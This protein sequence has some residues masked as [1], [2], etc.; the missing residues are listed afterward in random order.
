MHTPK[1]K[2]FTLIELLVVIAIIAILAAILFP[3]FAQARSAAK[4]TQVISNA[5]QIG[6]ASIMYANDHDD[7]FSPIANFQ[8]GWNLWSFVT[9]VEPYIKNFG[10]FMDPLGPAN[11][12]DNPFI[13]NSQWAMAPR[14]A[15]VTACPADTDTTGCALGAVNPAGLALAGGTALGRDGIAG[16]NKSLN[17]GFKTFIVDRYN[18]GV[19]SMSQSA[20]TRPSETMLVTQANHFDMLWG[21]RSLAPDRAFRHWGDPPFNL[22]GDMNM[23]CGPA[24][25]ANAQGTKAGIWPT[26][27]VDMTEF[28]EGI[29]VSVYSDGHAKSRNWREMNT[30]WVEGPGGTRYLAY[31]SPRF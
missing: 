19:P 6:L 3:V 13:L 18:G 8:D 20:I 7:L 21:S 4:R 17:G 22:Y 27:V 5:K 31:A 26:S 1:K 12:N 2:G 9:L 23:T 24:A 14:R 15:A 11:A 28:P 16:A 10:I 25:R 30:K 29:N